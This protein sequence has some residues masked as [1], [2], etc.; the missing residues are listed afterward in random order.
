MFEALTLN[1]DAVNRQEEEIRDRM[2]DLDHETRQR[3][4]ALAAKQTKAAESYAMC[5]YI[6]I[7]GL[8]HFYL[9]KTVR[10]LVNLAVFILGL[11][12]LPLYGAGLIFIIGITVVELPALFRSQTIV[13][14]HNNK[15][16]L[17]LLEMVG[18]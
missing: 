2:R 1:A 12:T 16:L 7:A 3:V 18:E 6:F 10:G 11:L 13:R 14:D 5:N 8:H 9:G 17:G 4:Y 15:V